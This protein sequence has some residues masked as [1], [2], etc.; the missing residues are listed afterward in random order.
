MGWHNYSAIWGRF[1]FSRDVSD[2][3]AVGSLASEHQVDDALCD[4]RVCYSGPGDDRMKFG[5]NIH[6][7]VAFILSIQRYFCRCEIYPDR[8]YLFSKSSYS[9][10]LQVEA[11]C[12]IGKGSSNWAATTRTAIG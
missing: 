7:S 11:A 1:N 12:M 5:V 4:F 9:R 2:D 3:L 8:H 6:Y 10:H